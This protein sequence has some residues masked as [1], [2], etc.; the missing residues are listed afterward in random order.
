MKYR[1]ISIELGAIGAAGTATKVQGLGSEVSGLQASLWAPAAEIASQH[2]L[3]LVD[4]LEPITQRSKLPIPLRQSPTAGWSGD[5][6]PGVN[7]LI[8]VITL[9]SIELSV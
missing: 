8:I 4:D 2:A 3:M 7:T 5:K 9:Y 1:C 6:N